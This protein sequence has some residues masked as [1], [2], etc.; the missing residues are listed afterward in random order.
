MPNRKK[1]TC[2][3]LW[4]HKSKTNTITSTAINTVTGYVITKT[5]IY[6]R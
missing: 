1:Q 5:R 3:E 6:L 4:G 2:T